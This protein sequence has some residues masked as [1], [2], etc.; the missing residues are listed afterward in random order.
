MKALG[1][2]L[3]FKTR[4]Q[5]VKYFRILTGHLSSAVEVEALEH[6]PKSLRRNILMYPSETSSGLSE[7][8]ERNVS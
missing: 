1:L 4:V 5:T 6:T 2:K 3:S 8:R 7:L